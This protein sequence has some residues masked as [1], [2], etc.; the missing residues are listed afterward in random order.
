M[1]HWRNLRLHTPGQG[2]IALAGSLRFQ[3]KPGF[4]EIHTVFS[5]A[6]SGEEHGGPP[7][8]LNAVPLIGAAE[9][10]VKSF[11]HS[12]SVKFTG[13]IDLRIIILRVHW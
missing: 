2:I 9:A 11:L 8:R 4:A 7:K 5:E 3:V 10:G 12:E 13:S 1:G 6:V